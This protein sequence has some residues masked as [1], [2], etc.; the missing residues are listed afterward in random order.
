MTDADRRLHHIARALSIGTL[1][2]HIFLC[3]DQK[4]PRCCDKGDSLRVWA[5]LKKRLKELHLTSAPPT[6]RGDG[7]SN[8]PH[9]VPGGCTILRTKVDC[10][11]I[12]ERGPIAVVY[13]EGTWYH[14]VTE[15]VME[16]I[17]QDH[18]VGGQIVASHAFAVDPLSS[19]GDA[20][21]PNQ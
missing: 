21:H 7:N 10:L 12:C 15:N 9:V 11:R 20:D 3:A 8:A 1:H 18:L 4:V 13:P 17:I 14:S 16:Q 19:Q 6:W 2:R 5:Y